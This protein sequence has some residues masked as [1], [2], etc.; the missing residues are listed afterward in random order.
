MEFKIDEDFV[1]LLKYLEL[2]DLLG[3]GKILNVEEEDD[4]EDYIAKI[5]LAWVE[6]PHKEKIRQLIEDVVYFNQNAETKKLEVKKF[7]IS[8][9]KSNKG[10][11][12]DKNKGK[13]EVKKRK[14]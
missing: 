10:K 7:N 13:I 1:S 12:K 5:Y 11:I 9:V 8:K 14:K 4:F 3:L 2:T 6:H